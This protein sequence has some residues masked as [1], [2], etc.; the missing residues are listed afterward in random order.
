MTQ[1]CFLLQFFRPLFHRL[2]LAAPQARQF[3]NP[4]EPQKAALSI[5]QT[6]GCWRQQARQ[7]QDKK[8]RSNV[9]VSSRSAL[10]WDPPHIFSVG[11]SDLW[12]TKQDSPPGSGWCEVIWDTSER[13]S[14]WQS[15]GQ[16]RH[17]VKCGVILIWL[18]ASGCC[19]VV[20]DTA[21]HAESPGF[22]Y[23]SEDRMLRRVFRGFPQSVYK[24]SGY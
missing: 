24:D 16:S 23:W 13:R 2:E 22:R 10:S 4:W 20:G 3:T 6:H 21:L 18:T 7:V 12:N 15:H 9:C 14:Q 1:Y 17:K 19:R 8:V 5:Q 11:C